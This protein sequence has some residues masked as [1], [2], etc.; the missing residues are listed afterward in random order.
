[1]GSRSSSTT[2]AFCKLRTCPTSET[3]LLY[4]DSALARDVTGGVKEHLS[5]CDF[6]GAELHLLSRFRPAGPAIIRPARMPWPL[7]RLAKDLFAASAR[8]ASLAAASIYDRDR[9]TLTDA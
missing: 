9:L 5:D 4:H 8:A 3:L 7:Y 2:A 6:C 1:M